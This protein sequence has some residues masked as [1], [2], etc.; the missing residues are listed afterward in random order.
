MSPLSMQVNPMH[1]T[2]PPDS[3]AYREVH[4]SL[5]AQWDNEVLRME[6]QSLKAE[7]ADTRE[8]LL[9]VSTKM[10]AL[11]IAVA[12]KCRRLE[13]HSELQAKEIVELRKA[14]QMAE[15][16]LHEEKL[17][18]LRSICTRMTTPSP[19]VTLEHEKVIELCTK[20]VA[21]LYE[22][23]IRRLQEE[24]KRTRTTSAT[25]AIS[26]ALIQA[27]AQIHTLEQRC[28]YLEGKIQRYKE[29]RRE[30]AA[31]GKDHAK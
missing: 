29:R 16:K 14:L 5:V 22:V 15:A 19:E 2:P 26:D 8:K 13:R 1:E 9:K 30:R 18:N 6:N 31:G 17:E 4:S 20:N 28:L 23:E 24:L 3:S 12:T 25:P 21:E 11:E 7:L 27:Q 10:Q